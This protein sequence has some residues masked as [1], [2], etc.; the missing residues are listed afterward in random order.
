MIMK[1]VL[2]VS[3]VGVFILSAFAGHQT[4]DNMA[5]NMNPKAATPQTQAAQN[6]APAPSEQITKEVRDTPY[7]KMLIIKRT[8]TKN[9]MH[10]SIVESM[11]LTE[12]QQHQA[13]AAPAAAP[14]KQPTTSTEDHHAVHQA[15]LQNQIFLDDQQQELREF[16]HQQQMFN[17][18]MAHM[19]QDNLRVQHQMEAQI[20]AI[21]QHLNQ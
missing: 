19:L 3:L 21:I 2:A 20:Q 15:L 9:G 18:Q 5:T 14:Q 13:K 10:Y 11:P 6:Q 12:A 16:V 7:G 17:R 8:G 4:A 1:K